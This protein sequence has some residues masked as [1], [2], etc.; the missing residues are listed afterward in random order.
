MEGPT[1]KVCAPRFANG[2]PF[3]ATSVSVLLVKAYLTTIM[4]GLAASA[5]GS[6]VLALGISVTAG[7]QHHR[8]EAWPWLFSVSAVPCA[9]L[10][11]LM[12]WLGSKISFRGG[13]FVCALLLAFSVVLLSGS[14]GAVAVESARR[15]IST[16]N[17]SGY[18]VWCWVYA[19]VLLP[20][21]YPLAVLVFYAAEKT[22][23]R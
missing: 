11:P 21:S 5:A 6:A 4:L 23:R 2:D 3:R 9:M 17:V 15:G 7:A 10:S 14:A 22:R 12:L 1:I 18:L 8:L 16:V 19:I 20:V 13:R